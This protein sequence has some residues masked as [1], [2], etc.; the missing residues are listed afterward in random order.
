MRR[1]CELFPR[2]QFSLNCHLPPL[3]GGVVFLQ[4]YS[5]KICAAVSVLAATLS[6]GSWMCANGAFVWL[7]HLLLFLTLGHLRHL[8]LM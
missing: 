5:E 8:A 1:M 3:Q 4:F 6:D 7:V 2:W